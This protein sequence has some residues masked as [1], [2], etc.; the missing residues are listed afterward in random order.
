MTK[1]TTLTENNEILVKNA[2]LGLVFVG[3]AV[4]VVIATPIAALGVSVIASAV[5][6]LGAVS[7]VALAPFAR[8]KI[9]EKMRDN[10]IAEVKSFGTDSERAKAIEVEDNIRNRED[11]SLIAMGRGAL[12][13][14]VMAMVGVVTNAGI[15]VI[16]GA[17]VVYLLRDKKRIEKYKVEGAQEKDIGELAKEIRA[18]R[19]NP[20]SSSKKHSM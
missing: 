20:Q 10:N 6:V 7:T 14:S 19:S 16:A 5:A 1:K 15:G 18:R 9:T 8:S 13:L 11:R 17:G 2:K 12:G 3:G 4:A